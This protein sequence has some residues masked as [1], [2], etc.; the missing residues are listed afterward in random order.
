MSPPCG[1][2]RQPWKWPCTVV[3]WLVA[4]AVTF[5]VVYVVTLHVCLTSGVVFDGPSVGWPITTMS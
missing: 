1:T 2:V 4:G 3:I 5:Y